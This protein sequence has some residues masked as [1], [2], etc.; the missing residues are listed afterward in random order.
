MKR[1]IAVLEEVDVDHRIAAGELQF[2]VDLIAELG[3]LLED[4]LVA[5]QLEIGLKDVG[6]DAERIF[7]GR[8]A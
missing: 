5:F 2:L 8:F 4:G 6:S 1:Q 7:T 3:Q